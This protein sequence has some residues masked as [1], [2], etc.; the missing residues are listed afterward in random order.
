M[1]VGSQSHAPA[2]LPPRITR[3]P[4]YRR[5]GGLKGRC[6]AGSEELA[7]HRDS[8]P[9]TS[10]LLWVAVP[11]ELSWAPLWTSAVSNFIH[12]KLQMLTTGRTS[13]RVGK[14]VTVLATVR[15]HHMQIYTGLHPTQQICTIPTATH[16][17]QSWQ[18]CH[19]TGDCSPASHADLHRTAPN[20]TNMHN[21]YSY[22]L[23]DAT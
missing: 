12:I 1:G 4:L 19:S 17:M 21:T 6:G 5:L 8:F 16:F 22:P 13:C 15:R 3:C 23:Y 20:S 2:A 14:T 10:D 9:G 18:D 7:P 11:T